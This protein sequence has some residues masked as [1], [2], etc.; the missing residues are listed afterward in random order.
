MKP[1]RWYSHVFSSPRHLASLSIIPP[2]SLYRD[3]NT[4]RTTG[5]IGGTG[6]KCMHKKSHRSGISECSFS[7]SLWIQIFTEGIWSG[8]L[9]EGCHRIKPQQGSSGR[10]LPNSRNGNGNRITVCSLVMHM[11]RLNKHSGTW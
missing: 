3:C 7:S 8:E 6:L 9:E 1:A 4:Q 11:R 10:R 2:Y 5:L